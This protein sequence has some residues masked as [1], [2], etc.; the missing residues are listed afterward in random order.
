MFY[1]ICNT[2]TLTGYKCGKTCP[3]LTEHSEKEVAVSTAVTMER[4]ETYCAGVLAD[5]QCQYMHIFFPPN[6]KEHPVSST[7]ALSCYCAHTYCDGPLTDAD[8][9]LKNKLT[10]KHRTTSEMLLY[11]SNQHQ[12]LVDIKFLK[13][14]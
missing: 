10:E 2:H 4:I 14:Y 5:Y 7:D 1:N 11:L 9:H 3:F 8:S 13:F 6:C 12:F